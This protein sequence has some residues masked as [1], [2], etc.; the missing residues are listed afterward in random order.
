[1]A[2]L[3]LEDDKTFSSIDIKSSREVVAI[4]GDLSQERLLNAYRA[5][6]FPWYSPGDPILWWSPD[7]RFVVRPCDVR[8][9]RSMR[10][11]LKR[12]TFSFTVDR[13]FRRVMRECGAPRKDHIDS[14]IDEAMI[15]AYTKLH[16]AG[17][18]HSVEAWQCSELVGGLYGISLGKMFFGESMFSRVSNSSKAAFIMLA[19]N[20]E[21][22]HFDLIDCQVYTEHLESLGARECDRMEFLSLLAKSLKKET[23]RG[24]WGGPELFRTQFPF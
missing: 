17:Y 1:M 4:G 12:E 6:I 15:E 23:M 8:V 9:S 14:W 10:R 21:R 16:E 13:E 20:L 18:A 2:V 3:L 24:N 5:G 22:M 7:P 11:V 19:R